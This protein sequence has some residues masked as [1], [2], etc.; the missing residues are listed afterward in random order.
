MFLVFDV[1][2]DY[3]TIFTMILSSIAVYEIWCRYLIT[4]LLLF[5]HLHAF[6]SPINR[7][8]ARLVS[9]RS[10]AAAVLP[11]PTVK[12]ISAG[13][14][15]GGTIGVMA[16][17][18]AANDKQQ[19]QRELVDNWSEPTN[20]ARNVRLNHCEWMESNQTHLSADNGPT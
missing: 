11:T 19:L 9:L 13:S 2:N 7:F 12:T 6:D 20:G 15:N 17:T 18:R 14:Q 10:P 8:S 1:E 5:I 3:I 16:A 4:T